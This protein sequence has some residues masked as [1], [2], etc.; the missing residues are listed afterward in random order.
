MTS[1][2]LTLLHVISCEAAFL[3]SLEIK[4]WDQDYVL[5]NNSDLHSW[6]L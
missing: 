5:G 6:S 3:H 1:L 4:A 2:Q